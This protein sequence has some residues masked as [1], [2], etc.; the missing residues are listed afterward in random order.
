MARTK[1]YVVNSVRQAQINGEKSKALTLSGENVEAVIDMFS[2][3]GP[4]ARYSSSERKINLSGWLNRGIDNWVLATI[5]CFKAMLLSGA[6][7]TSTVVQY[8]KSVRIFFSFLTS[9]SRESRIA[10]P[11]DFSPLHVKWFVEWLRI[12]GEG[13]SETVGTTRNIFKNVKSILIEMF[14]QGYIVGDKSRFFKRNSLPWKDSESRQT[15]LSDA[16]Q[17]RLA[18]AIKAD[19]VA[20]YHKRVELC[21]SD[22][23]AL[24]LLLVAHRQGANP[25][26]LL[27][28]Q[29]DAL[30]PGLLPGTIRV[31]T[32]K[33]RSRKIRSGV[34]RATPAN[35]QFETESG[36]ERPAEI[37]FG[38][39]EGAVLQQAITETEVLIADAPPRYKNRV[40]LYRAQPVGSTEPFVTCLT[41]ATIRQAI[42]RLVT[43]HQLRAD[44]GERLRLNLSR[45]RK[46]YFDRAFRTTD[47][48]LVKTANLMGNT[49]RVAGANYPSMNESRK[50]EAA[51]FMNQEYIE[52]MR[53]KSDSQQSRL[54]PVQPI[55]IF[56]AGSEGTGPSVITPISTPVSACI[57]TLNGE[58]APGNG[59]THCDRYVM[60]L[61][62]S[63]FAIVGS[64]DELWRLFSFQEFAKGELKYLDDVL[65][66]ELTED[67]E[68]EELRDRYRI[69]IPYIDDFTKKQFPPRVV[70]EARDKTEMSLHPF[71]NHQATMSRRARA[72][73]TGHE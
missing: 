45:T 43:R 50:A 65:G 61:F 5:F 70:N 32:A 3:L 1:N 60:C 72:Q 62:C 33:A 67:D 47:G 21:S 14:A 42:S 12:R 59:H 39:A 6:R 48:D 34:G 46:S 26:P 53:A 30:A 66:K 54:M 68:L 44:N 17:E 49:P 8:C 18:K 41:G 36:E 52:L 35:I 15:S 23:Q 25:T 40:W 22:V 63:S 55:K 29:R 57:N 27:E 7:E 28:L 58:H 9:G 20:S 13:G 11:E 31:R 64:A 71:W 69:A 4:S 2:L 73:S 38:L 51:E 56:A 19:L 16:E 10:A 24:R 37:I